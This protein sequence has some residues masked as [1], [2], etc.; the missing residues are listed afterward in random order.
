[1]VGYPTCRDVAFPL[2]DVIPCADQIRKR[3]LPHATLVIGLL[4]VPFT[5]PSI[6]AILPSIRTI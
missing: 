3:A 5:D 1:M 2:T 6:I 4:P